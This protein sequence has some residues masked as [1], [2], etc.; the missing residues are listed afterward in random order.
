MA[1]SS[2]STLRKRQ[3]KEFYRKAHS[4]LSEDDRDYLYNVLKEYQSYKR[5]DKLVQCLQSALDTPVKLDLLKDIRNLIP[6]AHLSLYDQLAPYH[7]MAHPFVPPI[8]STRGTHSAGHSTGHPRQKS[9]PALN[10]HISGYQT[11]PLNRGHRKEQGS[12][13][14]VNIDKHPDESLGFSIRGGSEHG[15]GVYVSEIDP[16]SVADRSGLQLGDQILEANNVNFDKVASSSAVRVLTGSNR[17]KLAVKRTGKIPGLKYA[18]EKTSW[19]DTNEHKIVDGQFFPHGSLHIPLDSQ[20]S[21]NGVKKVNLTT[22]KRGEFIGINI[23]GG[24]EYGLG[25]YVSKVDPGGLAEEKGIVDGDQIIAVNG[26][27]F[28]CITHSRAVEFLQTQSQLI[29]TIKH[30]GKFPVYKEMYAEYSWV[31]GEP[32]RRRRNRPATAPP[33]RPHSSYHPREDTPLV[34]SKAEVFTQTPSPTPSG[35][36]YSMA[37]QTE[38]VLSAQKDLIMP[39]HDDVYLQHPS[40]S[41]QESSPGGSPN[42]TL[43]DRP[44]TPMG[45]KALNINNANKGATVERTQSL[46]VET[47]ADKGSKENKKVKRSR[48]FRELLFGRKDK[49]SDSSQGSVRGKSKDKSKAAVK[50]GKGDKDK[51]LDET[52]GKKNGD[53]KKFG[54]GVGT[55]LMLQEAMQGSALKMV[56]DMARKLL[57]EDEAAAIVRHVKRYLEERDIESVVPPILAIL[58]KPEKMLLLREIRGVIYPTDLGRFD[59]MVSRQ[60][61][62][63]Y[64]ELSYVMNATS[65]M[66]M[67]RSGGKTYFGAPRK[68]IMEPVSGMSYMDVEQ[69]SSQ[70][71]HGQFRLKTEEERERENERKLALERI[72]KEKM[73]E[74][75]RESQKQSNETV[76]FP[77]LQAAGD[78]EDVDDDDLSDVESEL[79]A[80]S[81]LNTTPPSQNTST[82]LKVS[83]LASNSRE[84]NPSLPSSINSSPKQLYAVVKKD[85]KHQRPRVEQNPVYETVNV[86]FTGNDEEKEEERP[87][88]QYYTDSRGRLHIR[89]QDS[90]NG[91]RQLDVNDSEHKVENTTIQNEENT[92]VHKVEDTSEHYAVP[93]ITLTKP[94]TSDNPLPADLSH[95]DVA[96]PPPLPPPPPQE[97]LTDVAMATSTLPP[98]PGALTA[99]TSQESV[100]T[101]TAH[102]SLQEA[103]KDASTL[104]DDD[105]DDDDNNN[106][107]LS[108]AISEEAAASGSMDTSRSSSRSRS[109]ASFTAPPPPDTP[110]PHDGPMEEDDLT[111]GETVEA[112]STLTIELQKNV[113]SLGISI[114]GGKD[115][116]TQ[117]TVKVEKVFPGGA[118]AEQG[119]LKSGME[120]ISIDGESL[121]DVTHPQAVDIIRRAYNNKTNTTM[122]IV[123]VPLH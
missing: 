9:R 80:G 115:S 123:V 12:F 17:L 107:H 95:Y 3:L 72:R 53:L 106:F 92:T 85:R 82:P 102:S 23:R 13:L 2:T 38:E 116:R 4:L 104:E 52:D 73:E 122:E 78:Y 118:A 7:K 76:P 56:E 69:T 25:I 48:T 121:Q 46:R 91:R 24:S 37:I 14:T 111:D 96:T 84:P 81:S 16:G 22:T 63:A 35:E 34:E 15:L 31:D 90:D 49:T 27:N 110:P 43:R 67:R 113:R 119:I 5:V 11:L 87:G 100:S 75:K 45:M 39:H 40:T 93:N 19:F 101:Q 68:Q 33:P 89:E 97:E 65:P 59:S 74:R 108:V 28:E 1:T 51:R 41:Y 8:H 26:Q 86:T 62:E 71:S 112:P 117:P 114:S 61:L 55:Q 103:E 98:P 47:V 50:K 57:N 44:R 88:V 18:R 105:D 29:L 10:G 21:D 36:S 20:Q 64:E 77:K 32:R 60:E 99:W 6:A 42:A 109:A 120:I 30:I 94:N 70:I 83:P 58:D 66:P 79:R 54:K